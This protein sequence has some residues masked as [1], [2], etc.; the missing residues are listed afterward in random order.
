MVSIL[1]LNYRQ[2]KA[3]VRCVKNFLDQC[4][5]QS[6]E[7]LVIDNHSHD[8]S[9]SFIRAQLGKNPLVRILETPRNGGFGYGYNF[10]ATHARGKYLL[11]NNPDKLLSQSA[12]RTM[13]RLIEDDSTVGIVGPALWHTDGTRRLSMRRD[14]TIL[15]VLSRRSIL[16]FLFPHVLHEYLM[17]DV[18]PE[19]V[20]SVDWVVG[21]CFLIAHDLFT[22]LAGFDE[23]YFLFFEDA[24]LCRRVRALGKK[25]VYLPEAKVFDRPRRL[26]GES[27]FDLIFSW[28]G[29]MHLLSAWKYFWK[30]GA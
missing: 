26:S 21:G 17:L 11:I 20:H 7:I 25:V 5:D 4:T 28:T 29:R 18:Q 24:D 30:W 22:E 19:V 15:S 16:R 12:L 2:G 3:T 10:G 1:I 9:I 8:E 27:F 14:P 6:V 23:R 13:L